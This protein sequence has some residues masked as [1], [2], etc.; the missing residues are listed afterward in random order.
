V[1][2]LILA[3]QVFPDAPVCV[4]A[5]RDEADDRPSD[6]P[7]E[8]A[9]DPRVVAPRDRTAGGTWLGHN[10]HGVLAAVTNRWTDVDLAGERSRGRLVA[11]ALAASSAEAAARV[12]EDAVADASYAG[13][14]LVLAD[15]R[16]AVYCEW[17]GRLRVR[18]WRP[19]VHVVVNVGADGDF[20]VPDHRQK[21][22]ERQAVDARRARTALRPEPGET[23]PAWRDRAAAVLRDHEYAFCVHGDGF[24]TQSS[25]LLTLGAD[26]PDWRYADGPPCE[27]AYRPVSQF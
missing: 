8:Y 26:G 25:S 9:T 15:E 23:A 14:N 10:E 3:W 2:T 19:G 24:G 4:A 12:V 27:T 11:D 7:G 17:D 6:P 22:G 21:V 13:F 20:A 5:N 16:A 1:C 18:N